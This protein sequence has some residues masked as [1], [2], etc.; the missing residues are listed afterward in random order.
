MSARLFTIL[1]L[2]LSLWGCQKEG[3]LPSTPE[4][5][6][7]PRPLATAP[8]PPAVPLSAPAFLTAPLAAALVETTNEALP[9][10]RKF[11]KN[12]PLLVI[13]SQGPALL[14][15]PDELRDEAS[16]LLRDGDDPALKTR[17]GMSD[18]D[19][20]LLPPMSVSAALDADWLSGVVWIFPSSAAPDQIDPEVFR[21]QLV[22]A[23][24]ASNE[25][26]QALDFAGGVFR[27][28][29]RGKTFIATPLAALP[30]LEQTVLIHFDID[31]F[32]PLY[33]GE[34]KTPLHPLLFD[35]LSGLKERGWKVAAATVSH[36][37]LGADLP[38][39][40]RFLG[41]ELADVLQEPSL[42]ARDL[43]QTWQARANA[44]YLE[45]FMQKDKQKEIYEK[46]VKEEPA[47][48]SLRFALY[49]V[50]RQY[51]A[52]GVEAL[53]AL[54]QAARIDPIYALEYLSLADLAQQKGKPEKA[55][56]MVN[57]ARAA[58]PDDP[59]V[60]LKATRAMLNAGANEQAK[61]LLPEL[62]SLQWS[63]L[64]Y[65]ELAQETEGLIS[66]LKN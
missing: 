18:P 33:K 25:E 36:S 8:L 58:R 19:P 53:I 52:K 11:A 62:T 29:V 6:A 43:P 56:E 64:Y 54:D 21:Q 50:Y 2:I 23:G 30:A 5:K 16:K 59:F 27:G 12:R 34:I 63:T 39:Q 20:V 66:L 3:A 37:N 41:H 1:A 26:A 15:V 31:Y 60:L 10:W 57:L 32:K 51:T 49:H 65:P 47:D 45:N 28:R 40:T 35:L 55:V 48:A 9:I 61:T 17:T 13:V 46:L 4:T 44:L 42:L 22:A 14:P 7:P 24:F 38:L